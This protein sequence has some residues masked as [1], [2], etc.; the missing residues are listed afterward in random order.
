MRSRPLGALLVLRTCAEEE[1]RTALAH[2]LA[3]EA[4]AAGRRETLARLATDHA[5]RRAEAWNRL[6]SAP[7]SA[8]G[9]QAASRFVERLREE[10]GAIDGAVGASE[11]ALR[12][13]GD[14]AERRRDELAAARLGVRAIERYRE[15]WGE[16]R[17]RERERRAES[18]AEDAV[19]A[20]AAAR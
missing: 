18:D 19:S 13:A 12:A 3:A 4:D 9:L 5:R 15:R 14:G 8:A 16:A 20:R 1:A 2:A 10:A 7:A 11:D 17:R 6:V